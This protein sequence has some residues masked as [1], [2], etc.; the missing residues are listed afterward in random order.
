MVFTQYVLPNRSLSIRMKQSFFSWTT[1]SN[2]LEAA[3]RYADKA[4]LQQFLLDIFGDGPSALYGPLLNLN[5]TSHVPTM[6]YRMLSALNPF[7]VSFERKLF[8]TIVRSHPEVI[9][10]L[11]ADPRT[12]ASSST[13]VLVVSGSTVETTRSKSLINWMLEPRNSAMWLTTVD[14]LMEVMKLP[15]VLPEE[16]ATLAITSPEVLEE[17]LKAWL[18]PMMLNR[19]VGMYSDS[20]HR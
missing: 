1:L 7:K 2:Y 15:L 4:P 3:T 5:F 17:S 20:D 13:D 11:F 9:P 19:S 18:W 16:T 6:V 10:H 12:L 14:F 8:L